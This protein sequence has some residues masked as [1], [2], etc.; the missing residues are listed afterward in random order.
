MDPPAPQTY[1]NQETVDLADSLLPTVLNG[2]SKAEIVAYLNDPA[3]L[4][5]VDRLKQFCN[6]TYNA[7]NYRNRGLTY[8]CYQVI[9]EN[10][11]N[12][13]N[14]DPRNMWNLNYL[15]F[16]DPNAMNSSNF[17][18]AVLYCVKQN[19]N[20]YLKQT[21]TSQGLS[22]CNCYDFLK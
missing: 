7:Q 6:Q 9:W 1:W 12:V 11:G 4:S 3:N 15:M 16:T 17:I 19:L 22:Y 14:I 18:F 5:L 10:V 20:N 21:L 13:R 8:C 2:K